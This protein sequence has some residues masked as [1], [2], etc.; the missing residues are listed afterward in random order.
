V[1]AGG[2]RHGGSATGADVPEQ[3]PV[4]VGASASPAGNSGLT[5]RT[6]RSACGPYNSASAPDRAPLLGP[7]L[8]RL[9]QRDALRRAAAS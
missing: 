7:A 4:R 8:K 1:L 6:T 2:L 5:R 9:V 3:N